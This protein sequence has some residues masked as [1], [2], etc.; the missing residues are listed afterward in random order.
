MLDRF[1]PPSDEHVERLM[2]KADADRP[3]E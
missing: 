3:E 2:K 1:N